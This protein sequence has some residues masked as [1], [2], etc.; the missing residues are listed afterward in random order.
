MREREVQVG[1]VAL[2]DEVELLD[3]RADA[4]RVAVGQHAALRRPGRA[5][6]VDERVGV[7]G[8]D[9]VLTAAQLVGVA[10]GA[11]ALAQ[12][13]ER[14]LAA[15]R[16]DADGVAQLSQRPAHLLDLGELALVLAH[17]R[18]R[19]RVADDPLAL[20]GRVRG[21]DGHDD[22]ARRGHGQRDERPLR[23]CVGQDGHPVT[24]LEADRQEA[25][26]DLI[27]VG[28]DVGEGLLAPFAVLLEAQR[29]AIGVAG[30]GLAGEARHRL[31]MSL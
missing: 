22:A 4:R 5:G 15:A 18:P 24:G 27:D 2:V 9:R 6:G 11:A 19:A 3:G 1:D 25:E 30:R 13:G 20:L 29:G 8:P 12:L 16:L 31:V 23:P 17:D 7:V 10:A 14:Q 26:R 21:V 28:A